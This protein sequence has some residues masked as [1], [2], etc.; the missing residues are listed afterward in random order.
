MCS[1]DSGDNPELYKTKSEA[2]IL[3]H[4]RTF[5]FSSLNQISNPQHQQAITDHRGKEMLSSELH[6]QRKC[7][8]QLQGFSVQADT[9][10]EWTVAEEHTASITGELL[11][12][13]QYDRPLSGQTLSTPPP[14]TNIK[15]TLQMIQAS[16]T[17]RWE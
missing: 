17:V 12:G 3:F 16:P 10:R 5:V 9:S 6:R 1:F 7:R 15:I 11:G 13:E 2:S 14:W 4:A 8:H